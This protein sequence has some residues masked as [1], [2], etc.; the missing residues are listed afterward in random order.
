[1]ERPQVL[2]QR[3]QSKGPFF[4]TFPPWIREIMDHGSEFW[5][6]HQTRH[7]WSS[8]NQ[9][10]NK[11]KNLTHQGRGKNPAKS[12]WLLSTQILNIILWYSITITS[13]VIQLTT[14]LPPPR[15]IHFLNYFEFHF[16][17]LNIYQF[18]CYSLFTTPPPPN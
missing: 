16:M 7:G 17:I 13:I 11:T 18:Y 4:L 1:M 3:V 2:R 10:E 15:L 12:S 8:T 6:V 5:L 9:N 14:P